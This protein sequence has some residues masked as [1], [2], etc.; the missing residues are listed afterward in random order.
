M[1]KTVNHKEPGRLDLTR[2][3]DWVIRCLRAKT[4]VQTLEELAKV[5]DISPRTV[6]HVVSKSKKVNPSSKTIL[7]IAK[8]L[9]PSAVSFDVIRSLYADDAP[10]FVEPEPKLTWSGITV[11]NCVSEYD[12]TDHDFDSTKFRFEIDE[13]DVSPAELPIGLKSLR[14]QWLK[15]RQAKAARSRPLSNDPS[16]ALVDVDPD[17]SRPNGQYACTY[18]L[19]VKPCSYFDFLW[20]NTCLDEPIQFDSRS[21]TLREE[22]GLTSPRLADFQKANTVAA[23]ATPKLG[24][25]VVVIT[26]G[27]SV[28]VSCRSKDTAI[29]PGGYHLSVAEGIL[30]TD[31]NNS[32]RRSAF[33]VA[34]R[35]LNDE[36][37][38]IADSDDG[39][40]DK[41][42]HD[43]QES[44]LF[45]LGIVL[46]TLRIQPVL[47]FYLDARHLTFDQ[48]Y[49]KWKS[50]KDR[51]ENQNL[52]SMPWTAENAAKLVEGPIHG[53]KP[54]S[55][56]TRIKMEVSSN[57]AQAGFA[58][59][60]KHD[61]VDT[62]AK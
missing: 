59:A 19:R 15:E 14:D 39:S 11:P 50:A 26:A 9:N 42:K 33:A 56:N 27:P 40:K 35:G 2:F 28:V 22:L 58:L 45:C 29:A 1:A 62:S 52:I 41:S 6:D 30:V 46:D 49:E 13:T 34:I 36:L 57:H 61:F 32:K 47:F 51:P 5:A 20:P 53:A 18:I 24:A 7:A 25:G 55:P 37:G 12:F 48:I 31:V 3:R 38:L 23:F 21:T 44:S 4:P 17:R 10:L 16:Y 54:G 43:Y 8:A 60:A